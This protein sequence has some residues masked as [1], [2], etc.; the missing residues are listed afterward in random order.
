[1]EL[2][3]AMILLLM[4][5]ILLTTG[6]VNPGD[7]APDLVGK[8]DTTALPGPVTPSLPVP[9]NEMTTAP[10]T[11]THM[12]TLTILP[13]SQ[14]CPEREG[15]PYW[16][17][18]DPVKDLTRGD[19]II[20]RGETNIPVD[21]TIELIIYESS[22]HPHCKCC[23]DDDLRARVRVHKG[24]GCNNSFMFFFD[25]MNLRPQEYVLTAMYGEEISHADGRIFTIFKN[26]STA[27]IPATNLPSNLTTNTTLTLNPVWDVKHGEM[28]VLTGYT[29]KPDRAVLYSIRDIRYSASDCRFS[30]PGN[31]MSG[32]MYAN[33]NGEIPQPF[34]FRLNT[35][36]LDAGRYVVSLNA[37]CSGESAEKMFNIVS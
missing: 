26:Y 2:F 35:S 18:L 10:V 23:Y 15:D 16:I 17:A 3:R 12:E 32:T 34:S 1:M 29:G 14:R 24:P 8:P 9:S 19:Q 33:A 28:L 30:C 22:F 4:V 5:C 7:P 36:D 37:P 27:S 21:D 13:V 11:Q 6:C 31:V 20:L 25:S